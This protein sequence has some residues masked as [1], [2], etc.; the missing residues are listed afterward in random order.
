MRMS[1]GDCDPEQLLALA[2]AG[3][4]QARGRLLEIYRNYLALLARHQ[5]GRRLQ[6][7]IDASD[8][9]QEA[10]M[11]AHRDF[12][13]FRG[14]TEVELAGWLRRILATNLANLVDRYCGTKR[15]DVRL[16]HDLA[17]ELDRSSRALDG[18]LVAKQSSPSRQAARRDQAVVLADALEQL[19]IDYRQVL[20]LRHLEEQSFPDIARRM[21]RTVDSVKNLW[22]RALARLRQTLGGLP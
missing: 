7:K 19:P 12:G 10:F 13:Q 16:E 4:G 15:R 6:G 11:E 2:R 14:N 20:V 8:L 17:A 18:A 1:G 9:V 3:D 5:I 21:G 22:A